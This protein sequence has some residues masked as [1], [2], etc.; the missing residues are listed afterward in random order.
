MD[1]RKAPTQHTFA[2][3]GWQWKE[4]FSNIVWLENRKREETGC[5][6]TRK[7]FQVAQ[8]SR[9]ARLFRVDRSTWMLFSQSA[10]RWWCAVTLGEAKVSS[11]RIKFGKKYLHSVKVSVRS[12]K[13]EG[14]KRRKIEAKTKRRE[15]C[16]GS[17]C[18]KSHRFLAVSRRKVTRRSPWKWWPPQRTVLSKHRPTTAKVNFS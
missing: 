12:S 1:G 7:K 2:L 11:T 5:V 3:S 6:N 13:P 17:L 4:L 16:D 10:D 18:P 8:L 14:T 9:F 15:S